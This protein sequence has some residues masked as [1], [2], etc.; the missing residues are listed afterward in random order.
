MGIFKSDPAPNINGSNWRR[1]FWYKGWR[2]T[3]FRFDKLRQQF[4]RRSS[5]NG[6]NLVSPKITIIKL[7]YLV[8]KTSEL[9]AND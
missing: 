9:I 8:A 6:Y 3:A 1:F 5:A 2:E 7:G 4:G